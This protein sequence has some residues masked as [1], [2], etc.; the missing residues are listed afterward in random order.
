[1]SITYGIRGGTPVSPGWASGRYYFCPN[2]NSLSTSGSLGNNVLR[3]VPFYVPNAVAITKIGAEVTVIGE[4]GSKVR[5]GVYT[6]DG[7]GRPGTLVFDGGQI[8]GDSATVQEV[9]LGT[10]VPLGPGWYWAAGVV[11]SAPTTVPTLRV[12][13][14]MTAMTDAG[15]VIPTAGLA[16]NGWGATS[17]TG[18]LPATLTVTAISSAPRIFVKT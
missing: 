11:Q 16:I 14:A 9:T 15:A 8:N 6:D 5:L 10:P 4:V 7:L 13:S 2:T 12:P 17:I 18:A 1:M 3:A